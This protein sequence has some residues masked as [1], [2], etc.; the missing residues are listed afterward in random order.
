MSENKVP[1]HPRFAIGNAHP[2]GPDYIVSLIYPYRVV[3][4]HWTEG[5]DRPWLK[6]WPN[7]RPILN[8]DIAHASL[9]IQMRQI[10]QYY[11]RATD[12]PVPEYWDIPQISFNPQDDYI[13]AP[14]HTPPP[15]CLLL[16][17]T[18]SEWTGILQP[19]APRLW[20]VTD[21]RPARRGDGRPGAVEITYLPSWD[22]PPPE[23]PTDTRAT[24]AF[25]RRFTEQKNNL[26]PPEFP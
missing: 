1:S 12:R 11:A 2:D 6:Y 19:L 8:P 24:A 18:D 3:K 13:A 10:W 7:C 15:E 23:F 9:H 17:D 20:Q 25:F 14:S 21:C 5:V 26:H 22:G 16:E 4:I